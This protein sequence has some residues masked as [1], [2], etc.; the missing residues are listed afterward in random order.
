MILR[1]A[2]IFISLFIFLGFVFIFL[3]CNEISLITADILTYFQFIPS[4]LTFFNTGYALIGTG[5]ILLVI[6]TL[7]FGRIYCSTLCPLGTLQDIFIYISN[8]FKKKKY[9]YNKAYFLIR[10]SVLV[11]TILSGITG[12]LIIITLLDPYSIFGRIMSNFFVPLKDFSGNKVIEILRSGEIYLNYSFKTHKVGVIGFLIPVVYLIIISLL[13]LSKG[14]IYCNTVCPVG[15]FLGILS[16]LSFLKIRLDDKKCISCMKCE[17]IC[18]AGCIDA[19][20]KIL[21]YSRCINCF[22]C[23]DLCSYG[24]LDYGINRTGYSE[25]SRVSRRKFLINSFSV[26]TLFLGASGIILRKPVG[27]L[28]LNMKNIITPPGSIGI[29]HFTSTCTGCHLCVNACPT[30]VLR[31]F[32]RNRHNGKLQPAMDY[33]Q[34]FCDY[35]CTLCSSVCPTAAI[36]KIDLD[37]KKRTQIGITNLIK[38]RCIVYDKHQDCGACAEHCPTKAVYMVPYKDIYGPE[39]NKE[40]CIGCGACENVCPALPE[41]AIFVEKNTVH[42]YLEVNPETIDKK[43]INNEKMEEKEDF[44]F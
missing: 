39:T 14:R 15:A 42:K 8:R 2:R 32:V 16:K 29:N 24:A 6:I 4:I 34:A 26:S 12:L 22:N 27:R 23:L 10:Y 38:E 3:F 7:I 20:N 30:K 11:L 9:K 28:T 19:K 1:R 37:R 33:S 21:D 17:N 18:K 40:I 36:K 44:P 13:S 43:I 25:V 41:K 35:E 31:P 5:F